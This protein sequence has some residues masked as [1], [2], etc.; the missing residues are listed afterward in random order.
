MFCQKKE[1]SLFPGGVT[2]LE[3]SGCGRMNEV[4]FEKKEITEEEARK[5]CINKGITL[6]DLMS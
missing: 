2:L 1:E 3:C 4:P 5:I 6:E